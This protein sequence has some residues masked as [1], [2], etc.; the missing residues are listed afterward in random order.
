MRSAAL[1]ASIM[2]AVLAAC[3]G[4]PPVDLAG[5]V[6]CA[7]LASLSLAHTTVASAEIVG[8]GA[9]EPP[10]SQFPGPAPDYSQLPAFCRV[11]GS[12][13]PSSD[14]D[15]GFELW[16]PLVD[17]WNGRFMQTGNGGAAG[18]IVHPS[19]I[20][21][22][23]RGYAVANTDT[24]HEG[25]AGDFSWAVGHPEKLIDYQYRAV[26]ELT[27][28]GKALTDAHYGR[29]H[30]KA[31]WVGCSTG[32]RQGLKEAQRYPEDYDAIIAGA[33]ASN[34][35]P[36]MSLSIHI[37]N[38][39]GPGG[40]GVDKLPLLAEAATRACDD[41]DGV[42]DGVIARPEACTFD[43]ASLQ[44]G[45]GG[46]ADQ[47]LS[48][49]EVAAARRLYAGVVDGSGTVRLPGTGPGSEPLWA[50]Y[51]S[52]GFQIGTNLFRSTVVQDPDWDPATFDVDRDLA[53]AAARD[54]GAADAM[55]PDLSAFVERGGKLLVFHGTTDGLIPY[56]N[57]V[58]YHERVVAE[59]GQD[60]VDDHVAL[61]LVP[62]MDHCSGGA[63]AW[64]VDWLSALERWVEDGDTPGALP[65][66]HPA[67]AGNGGSFTRPVCP[68]PQVARYDGTGDTS[69][70][71]S[72]QC[73]SPQ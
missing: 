2:S 22:L 24:G 48:P 37:Q 71:A 10:P 17:D 27:L 11:V 13:A 68:Y 70:A 5:P 36:L 7:D 58:D 60:A 34:W 35:T 33:P 69:D 12:I 52:P 3:G 66:L 67:P 43:P 50:A 54:A 55:D 41:D 72:F 14:S 25:D 42:T 40:L 31:Y 49:T 19:L 18:S 32:G 47:C 23:L 1:S 73:M 65:A 61:Y 45:V 28:V 53:L 4:G 64:Q 29:A 6:A 62:G 20:D 16:L 30:D 39:L 59:L 56:G 44:C 8:A 15:I 21:P 46:D 63:G 9:F 57:S 26:H 51:A 38:N